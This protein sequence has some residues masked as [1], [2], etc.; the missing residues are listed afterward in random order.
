MLALLLTALLYGSVGIEK[1]VAR[2]CQAVGE[3]GIVVVAVVDILQC[4]DVVMNRE[5]KVLD[6]DLY[7]LTYIACCV[8]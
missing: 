2:V 3:L 8:L 5:G 6:A 7:P 4:A 1:D